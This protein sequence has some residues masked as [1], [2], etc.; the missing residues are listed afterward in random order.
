M[1]VR[2]QRPAVERAGDSI[3]VRLPDGTTK[4][5]PIEERRGP[6]PPDLCC[7]CGQSVELSD[8][9]RVRL[10]VS[11]I[12][13]GQ[14][15]TQSWGAHHRCVVERMHESVTGAGAFFGRSVE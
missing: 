11:W 10:S 5:I 4:A 8:P 6:V 14:E 1:S 12:D 3:L 9:E 2:R 15:S 7:F 13:D